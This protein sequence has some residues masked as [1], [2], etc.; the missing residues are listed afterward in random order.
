M[1]KPPVICNGCRWKR[2]GTT[3][4][5]HEAA[6]TSKIT[7]CDTG[8]VLWHYQSREGMNHNFDCAHRMPW[9]EGTSAWTRFKSWWLEA[10]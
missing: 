3:L 8:Q 5:M 7:D 10:F 9:P 6:R 4:C 2:H 1:S